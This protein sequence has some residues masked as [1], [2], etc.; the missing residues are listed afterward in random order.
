M[1]QRIDI[2]LAEYWFGYN[3]YYVFYDDEYMTQEPAA[4]TATA[5]KKAT[6]KKAS[7]AAAEQN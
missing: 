7:A 3:E 6:A 4:E 5:T 1:L 2:K